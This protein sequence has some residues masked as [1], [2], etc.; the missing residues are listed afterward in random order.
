MLSRSTTTTLAMINSSSATSNAL[1]A[2]VF[3]SK[4]TTNNLRR[5]P[6]CG[7]PKLSASGEYSVWDEAAEVLTPIV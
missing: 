7:R 4:I 5:Q 3:D 6:P 1:P 2:G